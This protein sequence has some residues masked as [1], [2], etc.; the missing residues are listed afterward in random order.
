MLVFD[1]E[2][3]ADES[4]VAFLPEPEAPANYKKP[5]AIA[6]YVAEA[7]LKQIS[8]MALDPAA[9]RILHMQA[10]MQEYTLTDFSTA[11]KTFLTFPFPSDP[12]H[13]ASSLHL[14]TSGCIVSTRQQHR[15][16][17]PSVTFWYMNQ[18]LI[19]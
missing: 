18:I 3:Y 1:L 5:E 12:T 16:D 2:T 11:T 8:R 4:A 13:L 6:E 19:Q 17:S 7:R 9:C 14:I 10:R 15:S